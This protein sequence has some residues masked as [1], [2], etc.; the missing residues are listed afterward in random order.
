VPGVSIVIPERLDQVHGT[1]Q[2]LD[3][4]RRSYLR[5]AADRLPTDRWSERDVEFLAADTKTGP[6][7]VRA[8]APRAVASGPE[9]RESV[10]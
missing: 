5:H 2:S 10:R 8:S 4:L 1:A 7:W 6:A 9:A 3:E